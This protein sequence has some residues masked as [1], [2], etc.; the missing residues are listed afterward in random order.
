MQPI[1]S[2]MKRTTADFTHSQA[3]RDVITS[4][5]KFLRE[6]PNTTRINVDPDEARRFCFCLD[7][8]LHNSSYDQRVFWPTLLINDMR[9]YEDFNLNTT[10]LLIPSLHEIETILVTADLL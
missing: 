8:Y 6:S 7:A 2:L 1:F 3:G 5:I 10:T 9:S 4:H